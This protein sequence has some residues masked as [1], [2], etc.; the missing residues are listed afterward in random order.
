[1]GKTNW[2]ETSIVR[3]MGFDSY[4]FKETLTLRIKR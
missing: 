2:S 4:K 1:M 3:D